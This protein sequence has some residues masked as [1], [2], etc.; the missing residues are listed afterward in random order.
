MAEIPL[1]PLATFLQAPDIIDLTFLCNQ[2]RPVNAHCDVGLRCKKPGLTSLHLSLFT[3]VYIAGDLSFETEYFGKLIGSCDNPLMKQ[4]TTGLFY[5]S[6]PTCAVYASLTLVLGNEARKGK[7][8][9]AVPAMR[10]VEP[11]D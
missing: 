10:V 8:Y 1:W 11:I 3:P 7:G 5:R 9:T 2:Q 4:Q 6:C